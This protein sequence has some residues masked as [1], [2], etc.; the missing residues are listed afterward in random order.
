M[1]ERLMHL[2]EFIS[3]EISFWQ[4]C[5]LPRMWTIGAGI[6]GK[7]VVW[8]S[9]S[10]VNPVDFPTKLRFYT[11]TVLKVEEQIFEEL[12]AFVHTTLLILAHI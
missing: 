12:W 6:E 1:F 11:I 3:S 7:T 2:Q 10:H 9:P 4:L 8:G 5:Y